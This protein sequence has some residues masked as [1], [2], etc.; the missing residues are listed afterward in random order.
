LTSLLLAQVDFRINERTD[1][2]LN[3]VT[4]KGKKGAQLLEENARLCTLVDDSCEKTVVRAGIRGKLMEVNERL[5][6]E[7]NMVTSHPEAEG[8]IAIAMPVHLGSDLTDKGRLLTWEA[9]SRVVNGLKA[10][11]APGTGSPDT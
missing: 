2:R 8:Y 9:Y 5:E 1:R 10:D 4:G 6:A 7:P 11:L 3:Q